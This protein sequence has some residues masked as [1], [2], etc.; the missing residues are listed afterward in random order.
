M[1]AGSR[2]SV[3]LPK[4]ARIRERVREAQARESSAVADVC[5]ASDALDRAC[6][7]RDATVAAANEVVGQ[8][9][10]A[11]ASAQIAL[12]RV[13]GVNRAALLLG[14]KPSELRTTA[15]SRKGESTDG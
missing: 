3:R 14:I 12:V 11:V 1:P 5:A 10:K 2:R 6:A 13:S 7:K 8:A 15:P 9:S 4:D